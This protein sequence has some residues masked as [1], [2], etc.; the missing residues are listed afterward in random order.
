M[1]AAPVAVQALLGQPE[2]VLE[3]MQEMETEEEARR[4]RDRAEADTDDEEDVSEFM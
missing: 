1:N 2:P 3:V 4:Q